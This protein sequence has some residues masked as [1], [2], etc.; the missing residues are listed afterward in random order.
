MLSCMLSSVYIINRLPSP[1]IQQLTPF[2]K[3][4]GTVPSYSN[5]KVFGSLCFA[6]TLQA[7]RSKFDSRAHK[8]VFLGYPSGSK[9]YILL[10]LK[11][12]QIFLSRDV[13]FHEL[14]FP[15]SFR[16]ITSPHVSSS[17]P[18][19]Q[20][21]P[22]FLEDIPS[23]APVSHVSP[24]SSS[25]P[26]IETTS[27]SPISFAVSPISPSPTLRCSTRPHHPPSYLHDYHCALMTTAEPSS[28]KSSPKYPL[29]S[30]L[31]YSSLSS[32]YKSF[33]LNV[34]AIPDP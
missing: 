28:S 30:V 3:L 23:P 32:S 7:H 1:I 22:T 16:S 13:V 11:L 25:I 27:S 14:L 34:T 12:N 9:A 19:I 5:F 4:H 17:D 15:F 18:T 21:F 29:S 8:C 24:S 10:N 31:S 6:S 26:S 20:S 2:E 33:V